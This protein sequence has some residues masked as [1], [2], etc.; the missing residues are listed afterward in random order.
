MK[1]LCKL[2]MLLALD[3][4]YYL[5]S[6]I[7][8]IKTKIFHGNVGNFDIQKINDKLKVRVCNEIGMTFATID[9]DYKG[10]LQEFLKNI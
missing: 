1:E 8:K 7:K 9:S 2:M 3:L 10:D 5:R 6:F 4:N